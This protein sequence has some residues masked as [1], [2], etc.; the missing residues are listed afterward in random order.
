MITGNTDWTTAINSSQKQ[1]LYVLDIAGMSVQIGNFAPSGLITGGGGILPIMN[2]P[3]GASQKVDE[4]SGHS[5]I[6]ELGIS[7]IDSGNTLKLLAADISAIGQ[8]AVFYLG[9]PGMDYADFVAMHTGRV[10]AIGRDVSGKMTISITDLLM[11]LVSD[12]FLNGGPDAWAR[13]Q[14]KNRFPVFPPA[15]LDNGVPISNDNPRYLS[16][17]P[18]D[19]LLAVLQNELGI[20]QADPPD[21]VV[22][23]GGGSGTGLAGFGINPTWTFYDGTDPMTLINPNPYVDVDAILALRDGQFSGDRMEFILTGTTDGKSW[24]ENQIL[25]PLGLYWITKANGQLTLKSMKH[26]TSTPSTVSLNYNEIVGIPE[27]NRLPVINMV[28]CSLPRSADGNGSSDAFP[29]TFVQQS[30]VSA[31]KATYVH[32]VSSDG[33]RLGLGGY[34]KLF[35]LVNRIFSRHA[36]ATPEYTI[37]TWLKNVVLEL[38]DFI[39]LTHPLMLD[40][41]TGSVGITD[42]L[43]EITE[44]TPDYAN[45]SVTLKVIDTRFISVP[46]GNFAIADDATGIADWSSASAPQKAAYVFVSGDD[47]LMSDSTPGNPIS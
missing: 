46:S 12:V 22:N 28:Q 6:S 25:Q 2:V 4:L 41:K 17:N 15:L 27:I 11:N 26:P 8:L 16:G 43:C 37:K 20:G 34:Q 29:M 32:T 40:L 44:R 23:T 24:I 21:L 7:S 35:L 10:A 13:G 31:Y 3:R 1:P 14:A 19:I 33:L 5:S 36:F 30:S 39:L 47:G 45:G 18:M 9:F 42:A 38:G